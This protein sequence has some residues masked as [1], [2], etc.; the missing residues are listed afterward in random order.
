MIECVT[1]NRNRTVAE[2]RHILTRSGGNMGEAGSVG[3]QF[4]RAA[5]FSLP[6]QGKDFDTIF[7]LAVEGGAD[8]VTQDDDT[9]EIIGPVESFKTLSDRLRTASVQVEEAGLRMLPN[10][11]MELSVE[12]TLQ[13]LRTIDALEELDDVQNVFSNLKISEEALAAMESE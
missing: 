4:N 6:G 1:E 2:I 7:E 12:Q 3:W 8:D 10:Q 5:Y 13:V 9:F 11:E